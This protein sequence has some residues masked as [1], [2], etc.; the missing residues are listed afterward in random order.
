MARVHD[1]S[2][3]DAGAKPS[4]RAKVLRAAMEAIAEVGPDRVRVQD[5]A[6]RAGMSTGHVMYYFGR[7]ER[8]LV[9]TLLLGEADLGVQ[10][11]RRVAAASDV[12]EALDR[13]VRLYLPSGPDDVRWKL[14]AQLIARPP[15][16]DETLRAFGAVIDSWAQALRDVVARGA[17]AGTVR[18]ADP[19]TLAYR[20][21]RLMDGYSLE[22]LLG[23]PGRTRAWAVREVR[24]ALEESLRPT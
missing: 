9:D 20:T 16:D 24:A 1:G 3:S 7:R 18:C 19:T 17:E 21:C 6:D 22:V 14:W 4:V 15:Q 11:D 23:T 2:T 10:R 13:I 8:I 5:V 12:W